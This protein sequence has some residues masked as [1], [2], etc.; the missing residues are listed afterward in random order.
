MYHRVNGEQ[1]VKIFLTSNNMNY[2][3]T[4]LSSF[5]KNIAVLEQS[6]LQ[7]KC[8]QLSLVCSASMSDTINNVI[9]VSHWKVS[10]II[11]IYSWAHYLAMYQC[12]DHLSMYGDSHDKDKTVIRPSWLY[13]G[14]PYIGKTY[15]Y[16]D[17]PLRPCRSCD[18]PVF[19]SSQT[20]HIYTNHISMS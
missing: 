7:W 12:K 19:I 14:D 11:L 4:N 3:P 2:C 18:K 15:S 10:G 9:W 13:Q 6:V 1:W 16:Q 17:I 8:Y 20:N 5:L